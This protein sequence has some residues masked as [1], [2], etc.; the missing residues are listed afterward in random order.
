MYFVQACCLDTRSRSPIILALHS[1]FNPAPH[2][3][4]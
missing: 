1:N 4:I 3:I 2:Q